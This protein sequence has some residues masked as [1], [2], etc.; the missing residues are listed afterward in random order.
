MHPRIHAQ[1]HPDAAALIIST[2]GEVTSFAALELRANRAARALRALGLSNGDTIAMAC[3]NRA[4]FLD[5]YWGAQRAGLTLV[6]LS[7]RLKATEIAYIVNDSGAKLLLISEQLAA[8]YAEL[9][10]IA[11]RYR[12]PFS[13]RRHW[14]DRHTSR[15]ACALRRAIGLAA[16]RRDDRRPNGVLIGHYGRAERHSFSGQRRL[17]NPSQ[18]RRDAVWAPLPIRRRDDLSLASAALSQRAVRVHTVGPSAGRRCSA[19]AA[20]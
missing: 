9:I 10:Q 14:R 18:R 16:R 1:N 4:E 6:P 20:I 13:H 2:T 12:R 3:E 19:D 8:I 15:L 17:S 5:I 11:R 7:T